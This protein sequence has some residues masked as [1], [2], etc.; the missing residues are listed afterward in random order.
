MRN[1][2]CVR[3]AFRVTAI[4]I[5]L[6][7]S[8]MTFAQGPPVLEAVM[9]A[10]DGAAR[11]TWSNSAD[12]PAQHLSFAWDIYAEQWAALGWENSI[13]YPFNTDATSGYMDLGFSG[14]YHAWIANQYFLVVYSNRVGANHASIFAAC[15]CIHKP[16]IC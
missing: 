7:V 3:I 12:P 10:G 8:V 13:W 11:L 15:Y 14:A 9:D 16:A 6:S 4:L 5:L 1:L 2:R